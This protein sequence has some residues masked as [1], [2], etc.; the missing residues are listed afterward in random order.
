MPSLS[1]SALPQP[2]ENRNPQDGSFSIE[3]STI[4]ITL[5]QWKGDGFS[6]STAQVAKGF[7]AFLGHK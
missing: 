3:A 4:E 1:P 5:G 2:H 7:A 6:Y